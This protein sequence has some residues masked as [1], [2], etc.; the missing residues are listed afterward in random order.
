MY[1]E[2]DHCIF[3]IFNTIGII[4]V[5]NIRQ[6]PFNNESEGKLFARLLSSPCYE[7]HDLFQA[8]QELRQSTQ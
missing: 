3:N 4:I 2:T 7:Y 6:I 1:I 5:T 8:Q